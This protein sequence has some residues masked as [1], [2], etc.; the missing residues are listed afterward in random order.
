[1][2]V[3]CDTTQALVCF[4]THPQALVLLLVSVCCDTAQTLV[5]LLVLVSCDT[6]K[7]LV[8]MLLSVCCDTAQTLVLL[9][10][11]FGRHPQ[12]LELLLVSV[13]CDTAQALVLLLVSVCCD[14]AQTLV[15]LLVSD[16]CWRDVHA[17]MTSPITVLTGPPTANFSLGWSVRKKER[18]MRD[19]AQSSGAV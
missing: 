12:A 17:S 16:G 6:A 18:R 8:L 7:G 2:L 13:C 15:L 5:L 19:L 10:M 3:S 1:M 9:L 11:C 14:T 4:G